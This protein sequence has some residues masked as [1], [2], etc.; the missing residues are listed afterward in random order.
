MA[1]TNHTVAEVADKVIPFSF[2]EV[3]SSLL[4]RYPNP[5]A[6]H[7]QCSDVVEAFTIGADGTLA[8]KGIT[9]KTS[10]FPKLFNQFKNSIGVDRRGVKT[11]A[12]AEEYLFDLHRRTISHLS[13]NIT[14]RN[15]LKTHEFVSYIDPSAASM[16]H[17]DAAR[18]L[19]KNTTSS[20]ECSASMLVKKQMACSS[21]IFYAEF[22]QRQVR[23]FAVSRWKKNSW[24]QSHGLCYSISKANYCP[25]L[26]NEFVDAGADK[27]TTAVARLREIQDRARVRAQNAS[28]RATEAIKNPK[29]IRHLQEVVKKVPK[30]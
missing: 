11:I 29:N 15:Y 30:V 18:L 13:R 1:S 8:G 14:S 5:L 4:W 17:I 22:M 7:I 16:Q 23:K 12:I 25:D 6:K 26:A 24:K 3:A 2:A 21:E 19:T 27:W 9:L 10:P 20:S 28:S